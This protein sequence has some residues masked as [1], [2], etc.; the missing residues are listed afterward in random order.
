[1]NTNIAQKNRPFAVYSFSVSSKLFQYKKPNQK[2]SSI[3]HQ[4]IPASSMRR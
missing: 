2:G 3:K 1:M 4:L